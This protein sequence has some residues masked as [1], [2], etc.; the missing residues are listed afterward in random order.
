VWWGLAGQEF[1]RDRGMCSLGQMNL[2]A[3]FKNIPFNIKCKQTKLR[4]P[5]RVP[6]NINGN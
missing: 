3:Q 2:T 4:V 5:M 6:E 1:E